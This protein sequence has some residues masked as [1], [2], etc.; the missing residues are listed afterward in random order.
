MRMI[1]PR[2]KHYNHDTF[3]PTIKRREDK[4]FQW[5]YV[6]PCLILDEEGLKKKDNEKELCFYEAKDGGSDWGDIAADS[7]KNGR[8]LC[9]KSARINHGF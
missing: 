5:M 8:G 3:K 9:K 7:N 1:R 2:R 4:I 6:V